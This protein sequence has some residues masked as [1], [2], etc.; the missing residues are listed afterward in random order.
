MS[1][2]PEFSRPCA[3]D[4][5]PADGQT[6]RLEANER[7]RAALARRFD[8]PSLDSLSGE[9]DVRPDSERG[10]V[11]VEGRVRASLA[12]ACS[13]TL[14]PVPET[15]DAEFRRVF[16]LSEEP[17][18]EEIEL[19]PEIEEPEPMPPGGL[20][21]GEVLVE[22]LAMAMNPYPRAEDADAVLASLAPTDEPEQ[23][24]ESPF[25]GLAS[26]RRHQGAG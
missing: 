24:E 17:P 26:L 7:E 9:M 22:E 19:D 2:A 15:V 18:A 23:E 25:A 6:F 11:E 3:V 1:P 10:V 5:L 4:R 21:L 8:L 12:Q 16:S 14:E 13:V 20:D